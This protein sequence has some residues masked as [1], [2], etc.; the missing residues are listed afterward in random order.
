MITAKFSSVS[1][2]HLDGLVW[3]SPLGRTYHTQPP[4]RGQTPASRRPSEV[5]CGALRCL[6]HAGVQDRRISDHTVTRK[7]K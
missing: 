7:V 1:V 5:R 2:C 3:T 4:P 6:H